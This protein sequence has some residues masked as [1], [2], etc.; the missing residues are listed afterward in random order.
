MGSSSRPRAG[1]AGRGA[2]VQTDVGT[3][4]S[5]TGGEP[6][7]PCRPEAVPG[8]GPRAR[9]LLGPG[10]VRSLNSSPCGRRREDSERLGSHISDKRDAQGAIQYDPVLSSGP[11]GSREIDFQSRQLSGVSVRW[12]DGN[13]FASDLAR[14]HRGWPGGRCSASQGGQSLSRALLP[15]TPRPG[16]PCTRLPS[17]AWRGHVLSDCSRGAAVLAVT[18]RCAHTHPEPMGTGPLPPL[19]TLSD[20]LGTGPP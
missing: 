11:C 15:A 10:P 4:G 14:G 2:G 8:P 16:P 3:R 1:R 17:G 20:Q 18:L 5:G 19:R 6:G 13:G 9:V 7:G 12:A